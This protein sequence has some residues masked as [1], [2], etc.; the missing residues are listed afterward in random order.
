M[1]HVWVTP[2]NTVAKL[3]PLNYVLGDAYFTCIAVHT[4]PHPCKPYGI[5][6][7]VLLSDGCQ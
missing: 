4:K 2:E 3:N 1:G 5:L 7:V 6:T